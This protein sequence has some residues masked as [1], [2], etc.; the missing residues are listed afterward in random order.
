MLHLFSQE[1]PRYVIPKETK[2]PLHPLFIQTPKSGHPQHPLLSPQ[3]LPC[4][5][6][7]SSKPKSATTSPEPAERTTS[8]RGTRGEDRASAPEA[9]AMGAPSVQAHDGG[10]DGSRK[11]KD[12]L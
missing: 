2:P 1:G 6:S 4:C 3:L 8:R 12:D 5:H 10:L 9:S 11:S 7:R